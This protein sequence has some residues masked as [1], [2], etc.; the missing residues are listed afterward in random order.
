MREQVAA[1][2]GVRGLDRPAYGLVAGWL[3]EPVRAGAG[4]EGGDV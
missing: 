4:R 3:D 1:L 2:G